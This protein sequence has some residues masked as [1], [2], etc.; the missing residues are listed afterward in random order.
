MK[1]GWLACAHLMILL[2][3]CGLQ[4]AVQRNQEAVEMSTCAIYENIQAIQ[5]SNQAIAENKQKLDQINATLSKVQ[6]K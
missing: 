3:G 5:M 1:T 6:E 2:S 4:G